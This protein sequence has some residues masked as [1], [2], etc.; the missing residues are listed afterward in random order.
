MPGIVLGVFLPHLPGFQ[1]VSL[2]QSLTAL[3]P[4]PSTFPARGPDKG[5]PPNFSDPALQGS[6]SQAPHPP[7][8][9]PAITHKHTHSAK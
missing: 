7:P 2:Q 5:P 9:T 4:W 1:G 3:S 6:F 8:L